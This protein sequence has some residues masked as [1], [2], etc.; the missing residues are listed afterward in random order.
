MRY[1]FIVNPAAGKSNA[2][3]ALLPGLTSYAREQGLTY[4]VEATQYPGHG[5]QLSRKWAQTGEEVCL[6][7]CGGDGTL[8]EVVNGAYG[9]SNASVVCFPC[10]TGN[11]FIRAFGDQNEFLDPAVLGGGKELVIDLMQTK[12]GF[13]AGVCSAGIDAAVAYGISKYRRIPFCGGEMAYRLSLVEN[14]CRHM[15]FPMTIWVDEERFDGEFLMVTIANGTTYGGGFCAA[16]LARVD[17]GELDVLLVKKISR[18]QVAAI[19][20]VY[21][22]GKHFENG[23]ITEKM[24]KVITYR[25]A[26]SV[27]I[28]SASFFYTT[29]DGECEK[30]G[31]FEVTAVPACLRMRL[32]AH[33]AERYLGNMQI[34]QRA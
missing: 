3:M 14:M 28:A 2:A 27:R 1:I 18:P 13:S 34:L 11:D 24:G 29:E 33:L 15:G 32:P 6:C 26:R 5:Q 12:N 23:R 19:L 9:F 21:Q 8:H 4:E 25:R 16:P 30:N 10:G 17:D 20:P 22:K 7:A 31:L